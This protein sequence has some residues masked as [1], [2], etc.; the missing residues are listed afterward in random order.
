[1][2]YCMR[3]SLAAKGPSF[4]RVIFPV[5][6]GS[7]LRGRVS[8]CIPGL[9]QSRVAK[10]YVGSPG[11]GRV[12]SLPKNVLSGGAYKYPDS[13]YH[14]S[15]FSIPSRCSSTYGERGVTKIK[16]EMVTISP[17]RCPN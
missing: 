13:V 4:L 6:F 1:M 7:V 3:V 12:L 2:S 5:A 15:L 8:R 11:S 10:L 16:N 17:V 9:I 14:R